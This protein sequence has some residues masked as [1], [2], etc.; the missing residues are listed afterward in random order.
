MR[1]NRREH[2]GL[3]Y[4]TFPSLEGFSELAHGITTRHGGITRRPSTA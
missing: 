2:N 1:L 3:A 4:Y